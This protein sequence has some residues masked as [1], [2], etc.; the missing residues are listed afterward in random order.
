LPTLEIHMNLRDLD[1]FIAVVES[2]SIVGASIK[3]HLTQPGITR[4]IQNLEEQ[5]GVPLLD[6]QSKPLRPT[7][8]GR[9]A[10]EHGRRVLRSFEDLRD[11]VSPSGD[12]QGEFRLGLMPYLSEPA[13][14]IPL[15]RMRDTYPQLT[16]RV[17]SGWSVGLIDQVTRNELDAAAVCLADGTAPPE[18]LTA[19]ALG[20]MDV[21]L[22]A[23]PSLR[24]P[25]P[26]RLTDLARYPWVMN[27]SGCGYRTYLKRLFDA[28]GLAL[29]V[30]IEAMAADLRMSL[31]ARGYGIGM[32]T[33]A[34][35]EHSPWRDRLEVIATPDF[36][37]RVRAYV[38]HRPPPGRL[39]APIDTFAQALAEGLRLPMPLAA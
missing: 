31:V 34:A 17:T 9:A 19:V 33:A 8:A 22:V 2:G 15:E 11:S 7:S 38:L 24:V 10:Y 27:E 12:I 29:K 14:A 26:A 3:L 21:I 1:A 13:L 32:I 30:G 39:A 20:A 5:L 25:Q 35:L 23:A 37:P 36:Q 18:E 6:R 28:A 16:M 4:R